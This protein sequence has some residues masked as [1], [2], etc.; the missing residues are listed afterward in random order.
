LHAPG[1]IAERIGVSLPLEKE[2]LR[3]LAAAGQIEMDR[4]KWRVVRVLAVD[5][6][7]DPAKNLAL[8]RHWARL[9]VER[10]ARDPLPQDGLFS[11]NL[12]AVSEEG[13]AKIRALHLAYYEKVR[14]VVEASTDA[15][16]VVLTNVQLVPLSV[17]RGSRTP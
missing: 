17:Q 6:R 4:G 11:Y 2:C 8:K 13:F 15:T 14:D 3:A 16:R 5:T 12:F 1:F 9:G 7:I 10:L